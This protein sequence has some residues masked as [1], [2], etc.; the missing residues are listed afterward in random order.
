MDERKFA[1]AHKLICENRENLGITGVTDVISFDE[2]QVICDTDMGVLILRG[3]N[4]HV[5]RLNLDSGDLDIH[6]EINS[7]SYEAG[8]ANRQSKSSFFGKLFK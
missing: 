3:A 7:I 4:L 6:G 2:E 1:R 8:G 5:S